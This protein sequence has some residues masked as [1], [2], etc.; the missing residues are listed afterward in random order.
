MQDNASNDANGSGNHKD[1]AESHEQA[2]PAKVSQYFG[3]S[4][5][6]VN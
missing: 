4:Y 6:C 5:T 1:R 2:A 3:W